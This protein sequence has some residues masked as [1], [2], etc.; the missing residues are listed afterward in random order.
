VRVNQEAKTL[1]KRRN[2][3]NSGGEGLFLV[4]FLVGVVGHTQLVTKK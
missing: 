1:L 4:V 2:F 3:G